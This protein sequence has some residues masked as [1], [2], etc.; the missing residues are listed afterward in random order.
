[1]LISSAVSMIRI[2][3]RLEAVCDSG[4]PGGDRPSHVK[5]C[6]IDPAAHISL[7]LK[8]LTVIIRSGNAVPFPGYGYS[9]CICS[10]CQVVEHHRIIQ[11]FSV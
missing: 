7:D 8:L 5:A 3:N 10:F 11:A 6:Q 9:I 4:D 2:K 1:M